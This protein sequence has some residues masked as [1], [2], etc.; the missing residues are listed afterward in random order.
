MSTES[1]PSVGRHVIQVNRPSVGMWLDSWPT[2]R[3]T[4]SVMYRSTVGGVLVDCQW[5]QCIVN[6]CFAK[7]AAVSLPTGDAKE[8]S[9]SSMLIC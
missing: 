6:C 7:K 9:V 5:Y 1:R 3:P 4:C 2:P 8:D